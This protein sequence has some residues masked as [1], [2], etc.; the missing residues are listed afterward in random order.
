MR[1][2]NPEFESKHKR[3]SGGKFAPKPNS[4][5]AASAPAHAVDLEATGLNSDE[6]HRRRLQEL[7]DSYG[8]LTSEELSVYHDVKNYYADDLM[9]EFS[10]QPSL[11]EPKQVFL[12]EQSQPDPDDDEGHL[13]YD[14]FYVEEG[15]G[16]EYTHIEE[17]GP[18]P[19]EEW[20]GQ[21][22]TDFDPALYKPWVEAKARIAQN[23]VLNAS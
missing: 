20:S 16:D 21:H 10:Y 1:A 13:R 8:S 12:L 17:F 14:L 9:A 7:S 5:Q 11:A 22:I 6:Q 4:R 3:S 23:V 2:S 15:F 19:P 18:F